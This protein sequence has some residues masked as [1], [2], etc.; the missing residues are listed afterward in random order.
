M[1]LRPLS[2][3]RFKDLI[4]DLGVLDLAR[5]AELEGLSLSNTSP[6]TTSLTLRFTP[7]EVG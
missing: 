4:V 3:A 1:S 7:A 6:G 2:S 5:F